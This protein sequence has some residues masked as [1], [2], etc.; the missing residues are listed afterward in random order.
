MPSLRVARGRSTA[1]E[2][3]FSGE[4]VIGRAEECD[5]R[6]FD[7]AASRRHAAVRKDGDD[8]AVVDLESLNG[9]WVNGARVDRHVLRTGDEITVRN[10][11]L[12][13]VADGAGQ[14]PTVIEDTSLKIESR[15]EPRRARVAGPD[16]EQVGGRQ[17]EGGQ[18]QRARKIR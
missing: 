13:F 10:L 1:E 11:T 14:R 3:P 15:V 9:T 16:D 2:F 7:E 4:V 12:V 6:V 8:F 5:I 17:G 18:D